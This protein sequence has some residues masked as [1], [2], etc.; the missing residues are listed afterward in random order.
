MGPSTKQVKVAHL[1][2][3]VAPAHEFVPRPVAE[4]DD[5]R[6]GSRLIES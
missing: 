4:V 2:H 3:A 6:V 5:H 1:L